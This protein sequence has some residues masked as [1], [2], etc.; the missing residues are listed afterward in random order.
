MVKDDTDPPIIPFVRLVASAPDRNLAM[1]VGSP[2]DP[3]VILLA[4]PKLKLPKPAVTMVFGG[5]QDYNERPMATGLEST[6]HDIAPASA[7]LHAGFIHRSVLVHQRDSGRAR[8]RVKRSIG[9]QGEFQT[10]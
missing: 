3:V 1:N 9:E 10:R 6:Y 8:T 7:Q 5:F 4:Y 2:R